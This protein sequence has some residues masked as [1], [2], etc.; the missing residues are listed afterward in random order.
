MISF[1]VEA[2]AIDGR[3]VALEKLETY[4]D[5]AECMAGLLSDGSPLLAY[6]GGTVS[7][8]R[9]DEGDW[10]VMSVKAVVP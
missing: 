2:V 4:Q 1:K 3:T 7:L 10:V 6:G 8:Y 9:L 5:A